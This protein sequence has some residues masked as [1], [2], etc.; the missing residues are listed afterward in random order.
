MND[1]FVIPEEDRSLVIVEEERT[2]C[3]PAELRDIEV[4][5]DGTSG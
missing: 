3:V 2:I 4:N 1:I 5:D